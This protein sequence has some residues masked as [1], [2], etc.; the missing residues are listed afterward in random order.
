MVGIRVHAPVDSDS[1]CIFCRSPVLLLF[2]CKKG[3]S[4]KHGMTNI[5]SIG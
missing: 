3:E 5:M 2:T 1:F 4:L